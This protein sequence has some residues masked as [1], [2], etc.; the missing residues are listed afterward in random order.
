[1]S[2]GGLGRLSYPSLCKAGKRRFLEL[3]PRHVPVTCNK[4]FTGK[5]LDDH[6]ELCHNPGVDASI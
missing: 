4:P 6:Q 5:R 2:C 3:V 1:M